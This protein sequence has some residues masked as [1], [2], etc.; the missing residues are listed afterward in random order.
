MALSALLIDVRGLFQSKADVIDRRKLVCDEGADDEFAGR[1]EVDAVRDSQ[2]THDVVH[3][4]AAA[5]VAALGRQEMP[6]WLEGHTGRGRGDL[7]ID[8]VESPQSLAIALRRGY[9]K[10]DPEGVR[11]GFGHHVIDLANARDVSSSPLGG[12]EGLRRAVH[13]ERLLI[14]RAEHD[15]HQIG[16]VLVQVGL[17]MRWPVIEPRSRET[18]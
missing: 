16:V 9:G 3:V 6:H 1:R 5:I 13:R 8:G 4:S 14:V 12:T 2:R 11:T 15:D 18:G 17:Q 10:P 7:G